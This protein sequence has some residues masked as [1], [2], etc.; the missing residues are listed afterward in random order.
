ME[1]VTLTIAGVVLTVS[2]G[3]AWGVRK[4][5]EVQKK[6]QEI[7]FY[8]AALVSCYRALRQYSDSYMFEECD[9]VLIRKCQ[10][11]LNQRFHGNYAM[12]FAQRQTL[13][14]KKALAVEVCWG[15]ANEMGLHLDEIRIEQMD[16]FSNGDFIVKGDYCM[17]RLKEAL[18]IADPDQL[19]R[20]ICH[21]LRHCMQCQALTNDRWGFSPQRIGTWLYCMEYY[22]RADAV[23]NYEPYL[24]QSIE[25]DANNFAE[26]IVPRRV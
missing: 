23:Y 26:A 3:V 17:I 4:Y 12:N 20:T 1:P 13:E 22:V 7:A 16:E 15:L 5:K 19:V 10:E 9:Q 6:N 25:V 18:L 8:N 14:E 21:E 11:Y 2:A 24:R